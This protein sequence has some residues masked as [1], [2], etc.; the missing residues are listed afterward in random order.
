MDTVLNALRRSTLTRHT[1]GALAAIAALYFLTTAVGPYRDLQIAQVAYL[2]CAAA[3]LT[4]LTGL[5]GQISL[6]H[7]AFMA[8][9]AYTAALVI[10]HWGWPLAA[11]LAAAA[12]VTALAGV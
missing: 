8:V 10:G 6:G 3:G 1:A 5:G 11:V 7:G 2:T 4:V 12:G 9:G